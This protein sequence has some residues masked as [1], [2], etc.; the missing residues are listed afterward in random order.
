MAGMDMLKEGNYNKSHC[1][2]CIFHPDVTKRLNLSAD[3]IAEIR[4]Y[5]ENF[6]SSHVCHKT[7]KTCY[8]GLEVQAKA[9]FD[10]GIIPVNSVDVMLQIS[11]LYLNK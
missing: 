7:E 6:K 3:R 10:K 1:K 8:G 9:M 11:K 4:E 5:L 2:N